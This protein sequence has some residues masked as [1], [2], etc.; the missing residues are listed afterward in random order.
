MPELL[1]IKS[2]ARC[3]K[4]TRVVVGGFLTAASPKGPKTALLS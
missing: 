2:P 4:V 3:V 1:M